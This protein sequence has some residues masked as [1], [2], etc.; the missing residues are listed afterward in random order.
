VGTTDDR[1]AIVSAL[2]DAAAVA[3]V[4]DL[5]DPEVA[6]ALAFD[7][8]QLVR[9]ST[10]EVSKGAFARA[11][12]RPPGAEY[13]DRHF[14]WVAVGLA[15]LVVGGL[16]F[17]V[18]VILLGTLAGVV[19]FLVVAAAFVLLAHAGSPVR[20]GSEGGAP[21]DVRDGGSGAG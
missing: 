1:V 17:E 12:A 20:A 16:A 14:R 5:V 15:A 7:A 4:E 19:G 18:G 9:M 6:E 21:G 8:G 2:E 3:V 10:G 13:R 11:I